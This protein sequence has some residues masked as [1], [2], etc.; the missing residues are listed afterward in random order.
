M[1]QPSIYHA[2]DGRTFIPTTFAEEFNKHDS[3]HRA[4]AALAME[5]KRCSVIASRLRRRGLDLR[6]FDSDRYGRRYNGRS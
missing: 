4:A 5:P 3:I 2:D 6:R 1:P